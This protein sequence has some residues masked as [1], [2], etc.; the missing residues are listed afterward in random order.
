MNT[1]IDNL[2]RERTQKCLTTECALPFLATHEYVVV[3]LPEILQYGSAMCAYIISVELIL[4]IQRI[5]NIIYDITYY[6]IEQF[7]FDYNK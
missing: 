7:M 5:T 4:P 2:I 3:S 6:N 1:Y